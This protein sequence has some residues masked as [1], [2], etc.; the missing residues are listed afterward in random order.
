MLFRG[1]THKFTFNGSHVLRPGDW[2]YWA[3]VPES[4]STQNL[5]EQCVEVQENSSSLNRA[6]ELSEDRSVQ[7]E[8]DQASN[9]EAV[10]YFVRLAQRDGNSFENGAFE[11]HNHK[12]VRGKRRLLPPSHPPPSPSPPS[13]PPP[14]HPPAWP[15][16]HII[17]NVELDGEPMDYEGDTEQLLLL[18][19]GFV[20]DLTLSGNHILDANDNVY[21]ISSTDSTSNAI[22]LSTQCEEQ[23]NSTTVLVGELDNY[24]ETP[25]DLQETTNAY[26]D[27]FLCVQEDNIRLGAHR[28]K[29]MHVSMAPPPPPA[30]PR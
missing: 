7:L 25:I 26:G 20:Y 3:Q 12:R 24:R 23:L 29:R 21:W 30:P 28:H 11:A 1:F 22:L 14:P 16:P 13:L 2:A 19:V 9:V 5:I 17:I 10:E 6:Y 15:P 27:Y 8:F 4:L 18:Y